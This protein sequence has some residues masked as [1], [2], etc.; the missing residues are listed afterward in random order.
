MLN[1][2]PDSQI[3]SLTRGPVRHPVKAR[4]PRVLILSD[5]PTAS[6]DIAVQLRRE[7]LDILLS[8]FD[9]KNLLETPKHAPDAVLCHLTDYVERGPDIARVLRAHFAPRNPPIIGALSRPNPASSSEFDSCLF[10]PIHPAQIAQRVNSMIRLG[11]MEAELGR[12]I[13]TL[14]E[15]FHQDIDLTDISLDKKLRVLFIGK[16]T[17]SFMVVINALQSKGVEVVAAFTSFSAFDYLYGKPFDAVVMNAL[18]QSEPALTITETM[19]RNARLY[20]VP[21]LFLTDSDVFKDTDAAYRSGA[22]DIITSNSSAEEIGGRILEI[23]NYRS[24]HERFKA[25]FVAIASPE[26]RDK[27]L[28]VFN[29]KFLQNHLP[30]MAADAKRDGKPL[31]LLAL[32]LEQSGSATDQHSDMSDEFGGLLSDLVRMQDVVCHIGDGNFV[33]G[34]TDTTAAE[35]QGVGHRISKLIKGHIFMS[36]NRDAPSHSVQLNVRVFAASDFETHL[37]LLDAVVL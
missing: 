28:P 33:I 31:T 10:E 32:K 29:F 12:R 16:A 13:E 14:R 2:A 37:D 22:S 11:R 34:M 27:A 19:R 18:E 24:I 17:P 3:T 26:A 23:A 7:G 4:K 36:P 21:T 15:D 6:R 25:Q 8:C 20:H 1:I 35:A 30:R 9:G 5:N